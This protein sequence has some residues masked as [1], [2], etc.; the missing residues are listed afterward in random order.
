M[1]FPEIIAEI[2]INH[3]GDMD[4]AIR[5]IDAVAVTGCK[6]VK[7]QCHILED[8]MI[9]L[10]RT[11]IP[12]NA[13]ED[14]YSIM[15]KAALNEEQERELK[16]Y[17]E[18]RGLQYLCTP[19]SRAAAERLDRMGVSMFKIGSGECNN[20]P[21]LKHINAMGRPIILSTG[22]NDI[23][24]IYRALD[25]ITQPVALMHC[26]SMY[27]TPYDQVHLGAMQELQREFQIPVGLSDHS[28]GI[29]TALAAIALGADI[30]EKH[31]TLDR[32]WEGPD[33]SISII[34]FELRQLVEGNNAIRQAK[35]GRKEIQHGET[36]TIAFASASVVSIAPIRSGQVLDYDNTWVKRPGGGIPA[37]EFYS[38]L[39]RT[40]KRDIPTD[41]Q[42]ERDWIE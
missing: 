7:F 14:I 26:V 9:P 30:V 3:N 32:Q 11:V 10:A 38:L 34:P 13:K 20:Y 8:E 39:G 37:S 40:C 21:L 25:Y 18:W 27:P 4:K 12:G 41:V 23:Q 2:G 15:E 31:F 36:S 33:N 19:F 35:G 22:M 24:G 6:C 29:Y 1:N 28:L 16:E 42:I 17:A 5:M